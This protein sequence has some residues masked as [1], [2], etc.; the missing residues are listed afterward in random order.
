MVIDMQRVCLK[1]SLV[2]FHAALLNMELALAWL[3]PSVKQKCFYMQKRIKFAYQRK[4]TIKISNLSTKLT[5]NIIT[6]T[7]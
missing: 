4:K 5:Q 1:A 7:P 2:T 6:T 3:T